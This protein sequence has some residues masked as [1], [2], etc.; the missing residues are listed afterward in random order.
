MAAAAA[1]DLLDVF[2]LLGEAVPF[3]AQ[4]VFAHVRETLPP[5]RADAVRALGRQLGFA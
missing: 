5:E 1:L 3:D 2:E 4:T